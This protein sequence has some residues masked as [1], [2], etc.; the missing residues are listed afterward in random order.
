MNMS[1]N[2]SDNRDAHQ[3]ARQN[4]CQSVCQE[5]LDARILF[6]LLTRLSPQGTQGF[7]LTEVLIVVFIAAILAAIAAPGWLTFMNRQRVAVANREVLMLLREA[8]TEAIAKRTTY[9]V[10]LDPAAADGPT[11]AKFTTKGQNS[12]PA[13][14]AN[15]T[16]RIVISTQ[17]L[18]EQ[19]PGAG[20]NGLVL[21]TVPNNPNNEYRFRFDGSVDKGFIPAAAGEYVYKIQLE[22]NGTRRCVIVETL[23]G[24][25]SE[26]AGDECDA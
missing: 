5:T 4:V 24:A 7:T 3:Y 23:L 6:R 12:D 15:V 9:G 1:V 13:D 26:G 22:Q 2:R 17:L 10:L 25:M 18:G 20:N 21:T 14:P 11:I 16:N 19:K 8:Q